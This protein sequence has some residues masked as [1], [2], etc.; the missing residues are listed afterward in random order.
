MSRT[1]EWNFENFILCEQ[2]VRLKL[3]FEFREEFQQRQE[4]SEMQH[5]ELHKST[6]I[7]L[8][9]ATLSHNLWIAYISSKD[10]NCQSCPQC[11]I[12]RKNLNWIRQNWVC[13]LIISIRV[14]RFSNWWSRELWLIVQRRLEAIDTPFKQ[15]TSYTK[16]SNLLSRLSNAEFA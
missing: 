8:H 4:H 3:K 13:K 6:G 1:D 12:R 2:S 14:S 15:P 9:L 5:N 10:T 16:N 11:S 7:N